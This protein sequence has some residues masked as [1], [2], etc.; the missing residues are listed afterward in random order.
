PG[1]FE[2]IRVM[3]QLKS[4]V[5]KVEIRQVRRSEMRESPIRHDTLPDHVLIRIRNVH[6]ALRDVM[7]CPLAHMI[8]NFRRD[9]RPERELQTW[10]R[11]VS[12]LSLALE[13]MKSPREKT[14][15]DLFSALV[16]LSLGG[17]D[18]VESEVAQGK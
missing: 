11:I 13:K 2:K 17:N 14:K 9:F 15:R 1:L 6:N 3:A 12:A 7:Q 16:L 10:E 18:A 8:D 4:G 5:G